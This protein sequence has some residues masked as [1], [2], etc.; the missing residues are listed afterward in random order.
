MLGRHC[1]FNGKIIL[2]QN[3]G[4]PLNDIGITRG[5]GVFDFLRTY[6][7]KPFLL[8]EHLER[9][10]GSAAYLNLQVPFSRTV[11]TR[12]I[13]ALIEKSGF[14]EVQLRIVLTGGPSK[15]S[16]HITKPMFYILAEKAV[17][18]PD[19]WYERGIVTVTNEYQ[20]ELPQ[21]KSNNYTHAAHL[22][23]QKRYEGIPEILYVSN[24]KVLEGTTSNV[25]FVIGDKLATPRHDILIGMTRNFVL[26]LARKHRVIKTE[27]RDIAT[28]EMRRATEAFFTS[29]NKEI[30]PIR[31][32][33]DNMIGDG[34]VGPYTKEIMKCF[35]SSI[36]SI[37]GQK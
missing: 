8:D 12:A 25:F 29:T 21:A 17:L 5:Y 31:R 23:N 11:I 7:K 4:L 1:F 3:A 36:I 13:H 18:P 10:F 14:E 9:F 19:E 37:A 27:E 24:G 26:K 6:E 30:L 20:R 15:D 16:I 22:R 33:D 35:R 32:I 28:M 2:F 34:H